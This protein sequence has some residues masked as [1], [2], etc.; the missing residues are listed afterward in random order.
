MF[1]WAVAKNYD[2]PVT[3]FIGS[4]L[5]WIGFVMPFN[6]GWSEAPFFPSIMYGIGFI[7]IGWFLKRWR[8]FAP[9]IRECGFGSMLMMLFALCMWS[10]AIWS[11]FYGVAYGIGLIF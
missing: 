9:F 10:G 1:P 4:M 3:G 11:I 5:H 7:A 8:G 6:F 2:A